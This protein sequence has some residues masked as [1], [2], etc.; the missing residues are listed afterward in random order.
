MAAAQPARNPIYDIPSFMAFEIDAKGPSLY[1]WNI[2][3][4]NEWFTDSL[5]KEE[6]VKI[7][8]TNMAAGTAIG[9]A[10]GAVAGIGAAWATGAVCEYLSLSDEKK[11]LIMI[12]NGAKAA[13][14]TT[15]GFVGMVVGLVRG[16]LAVQRFRLER[17]LVMH[18]TLEGS[19]KAKQIIKSF[20]TLRLEGENDENDALF[21]P[22]TQE[23]MVYP[24]D[25]Q[26]GSSVPHTFEFF[27][28]LKW[29]EQS[30]RCPTCNRVVT[31]G[32]LE[33]NL[34]VESDIHLLVAEIFIKMEAILQNLPKR[35]CGLDSLP[36]FFESHNIS[37][38]ANK[39]KEGTSFLSG[40]IKD[41]QA[42]IEDPST[43]SLEETF[44]LGYFL[45][46]QFRPLKKKIDDIY[47]VLSTQLLNMRIAG[48]MDDDAFA[49]QSSEVE[50]WYSNFNIIPQECKAI[51]KLYSM[52]HG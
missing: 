27:S 22:I 29:L 43:L 38:L 31:A 19:E 34:A 33:R 1:Q 21:C 45:I 46:H 41:I 47:R 5:G 37:E 44:A 28:I 24:V 39:A 17:P 13:T 20:I 4:Y 14:A 15:G 40:D 12:T 25:V 50:K 36:N 32:K 11:S 52:R 26:C 6:V 48:T 16:V 9:A 42:K 18:Q 2:R 35:L 51:K 8:G 30:S 49:V 7:I 23:V 3:P 10:V